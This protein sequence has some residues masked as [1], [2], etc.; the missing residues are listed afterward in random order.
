[1]AGE[2]VP[3]WYCMN[4][5]W[6]SSAVSRTSGR[7]C[8]GEKTRQAVLRL[9]N[10]ND[11]QCRVVPHPDNRNN[12]SNYDAYGLSKQPLSL[13]YCH[14]TTLSSTGLAHPQICG[15]RRRQPRCFLRAPESVPAEYGTN[16]R[17]RGGKSELLGR[18]SPNPLDLTR[19]KGSPPRP[20]LSS[21][22]LI[23]A[24]CTSYISR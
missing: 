18:G 19:A 9:I 5:G 4:D 13:I 2:A 3:S 6:L 15:H 16:M 1:V 14:S 10:F 17:K 8:V 12:L 11:L 7:P 22:W 24:G 21:C 23:A 20:S